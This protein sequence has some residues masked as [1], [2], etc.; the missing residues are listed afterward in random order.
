[1]KERSKRLPYILLTALLCGIIQLFLPWWTLTLA[2]ALVAMLHKSGNRR[3][4]FWAG[5]WGVALLWLGYV[6]LIEVQSRA[7][8]SPKLAALLHL[9]AYPPSAW[10]V[11]ALLGGITGGL[12]A[13]TGYYLKRIFVKERKGYFY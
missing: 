10:I 12:G 6:L 3:D 8:L 7:I 5:F 9:P 4:A 11:T 13:L 1:M 2:A